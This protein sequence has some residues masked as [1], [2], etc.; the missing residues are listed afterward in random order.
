MRAAD[1]IRSTYALKK[2]NTTGP[3]SWQRLTNEK[4]DEA[5]A[6]DLDRVLEEH[7]QLRAGLCV[8][9]NRCRD[10]EGWCDWML[11]RNKMAV[12]IQLLLASVLDE[13]SDD[14]QP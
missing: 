7:E 9:M 4:F 6:A 8:I 1:R 12:H 11:T 13:E 5:I 2:S 10:R 3:E 14:D